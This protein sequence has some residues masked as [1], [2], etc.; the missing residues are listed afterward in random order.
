MTPR[1]CR[2][3]AAAAGWRC[4][5]CEELLCPRCVA[6]RDVRPVSLT[7]CT[8]CGN[9]AEPLRRH[10]R[11]VASFVARLPG[12]LRYPFRDEGLYGFLALTVG[13]AVANTLGDTVVLVAW[14][15][16]IGALFGVTRSTARGSDHLEMGDF[17][18]PVTDLAL[19]FGLFGVATLP[20]WGSVWLARHLHS[21]ALLVVAG[22]LGVLWAPMALLG[23]ATNTSPV[24]MLNPLR[25]YGL[26]LRVGRDYLVYVAAL[27]GCV[28]LT[29]VNGVL[30]VFA[31]QTQLAVVSQL[32]GAALLVYWPFVAAHLGGLVLY[33]HGDAME[34]GTPDQYYEPVL[35][36]AQPA[37]A[38]AEHLTAEA[39][40][41]RSYAPIELD[42]EPAAHQPDVPAPPPK[43]PALTSLDAS[44]LPELPAAE[45]RPLVH[46][47]VL[48]P[49]QL[50]PAPPDGGAPLPTSSSPSPS[51]LPPAPPD[52]GASPEAW[53]A[54][55]GEG[56]ARRR[57]SMDP[58]ALPQLV[59]FDEPVPD[60]GPTAHLRT[61]DAGALPPLSAAVE[62][63]IR[64]AMRDGDGDA[65]LDAWAHANRHTPGLNASELT[66][67]ARAAAAK[68]ADDEAVAAF[69]AAAAAPDA[70]AAPA[71]V[72]LARFLDERLGR[73]AEAVSWMQRVVA[74]N[75]GT[76]AARFAATWLARR[77]G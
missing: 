18:D 15:A 48:D 49:S 52:G 35:G 3:H 22:A 6:V 56:R 59:R 32:V 76:D 8:L 1:T 46:Q 39:T 44:A 45:E 54:A 13:L 34:W 16:I 19:P 71:R 41:S 50:P 30:A 58:G 24:S 51:R 2:T 23:A 10:R 77:P 25:M 72:L 9:L 17:S 26:A 69:E 63:A 47:R 70:Q 4:T 21:T 38:I 55:A 53:P 67:L 40:P 74:E 36:D 62:S 61:L 66:W 43:R 28:L 64:T 68:G 5:H 57:A 42:A 7:A 14:L 20:V 12:A 11:E 29:L 73:G 31:W 65:A 27:V 37:G 75:E 60:E 33:L